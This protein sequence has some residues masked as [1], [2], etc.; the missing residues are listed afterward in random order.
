MSNHV[1]PLDRRYSYIVSASIIHLYNF[2]SISKEH[3]SKEGQHLTPQGPNGLSSGD[4][5]NISKKTLNPGEIW[6]LSP[7]G[8]RQYRPL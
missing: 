1:E 2:S 7:H 4:R 6:P 8:L 3:F 5:R